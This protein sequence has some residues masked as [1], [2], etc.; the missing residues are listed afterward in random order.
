MTE[1][2]KQP[3]LIERKPNINPNDN[4]EPTESDGNKEFSFSEVTFHLIS[5]GFVLAL[6]PPFSC[7]KQD[8]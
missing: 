3:F 5:L 1:K 6:P 7:S 4:S 8:Y 2:G